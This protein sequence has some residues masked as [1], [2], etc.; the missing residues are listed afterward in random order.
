[1]SN[2]IDDMAHD[3]GKAFIGAGVTV[4]SLILCAGIIIGALLV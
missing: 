1:M 2:N 4:A 3:V